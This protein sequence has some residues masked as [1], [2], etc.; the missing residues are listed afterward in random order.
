VSLYKSLETP[1]SWRTDVAP[2]L[3]LTAGVNNKIKFHLCDSPNSVETPVLR[4]GGIKIRFYE[5]PIFREL[6][7][8]PVTSDIREGDTTVSVNIKLPVGIPRGYYRAQVE[9]W[10][11]TPE[12]VEDLYHCWV[13]V[14]KHINPV[15]DNY[16]DINSVRM[17]FA[18]V[19][20]LDNKM[21]E[22]LEISSGDIAS[23]VCRCLEQWRDTAPRVSSY[24]GSNF[25]YPEILRNGVLYTLLQSLWTFLERNRMNYQAGGVTVDLESRANAFGSLR[26]E[27]ERMWRLGMQQAKMQENV[28]SFDQGLWYE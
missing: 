16:M 6:P 21:L 4:Y 5:I 15:P 7:V 1:V 8:E 10:V 18:D 25:P 24:T 2:C 28:M 19:C 3:V 14:D 22:S 20:A 23:S 13:V 11:T 26:T 9:R 12:E 17:Q 27:Y